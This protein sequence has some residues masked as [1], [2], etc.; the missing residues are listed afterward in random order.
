MNENFLQ[1]NPLTM[2]DDLEQIPEEIFENVTDRSEIQALMSTVCE[3]DDF[4]RVLKSLGKQFLIKNKEKMNE[5]IQKANNGEY[6]NGSKKEMIY[7]FASHTISLMDQLIQYN[8]A[9]QEVEVKVF[10]CDKD[11]KLPKYIHGGDAGMDIYANESCVI[12]PGETK[13]IK[14]GIKVAIPGGYEIQIRPRSGMSFKTGIRVAN[15]PGTIDC[16]YREE[17]GVI[18]TNQGLEPFGIEKGD[19][20]AQMVLMRVPHIKWVPT[21]EKEFEELKTDRGMGFGSSGK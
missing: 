2:F 20:I 18:L 1:Q 17:I 4:S 12:G 14:T 19:R 8:G 10:L 11:A 16:E 6:G 7:S 13:I 15:A 21:T 9:F 5:Y 3:N